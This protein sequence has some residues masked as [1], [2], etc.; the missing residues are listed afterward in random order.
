MPFAKAKRKRVLG[1]SAYHGD[2]DDSRSRNLTDD[3]GATISLED[4]FTYSCYRLV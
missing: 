4:L 2:N 1:D 3:G